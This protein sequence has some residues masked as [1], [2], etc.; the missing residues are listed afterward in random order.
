[1]WDLPYD[2]LTDVRESL[3]AVDVEYV[4]LSTEDHPAMPIRPGAN[5]QM[6][7]GGGGGTLGQ[8]QDGKYP[9]TMNWGLKTFVDAGPNRPGGTRLSLFVK[10]GDTTERLSA[11]SGTGVIIV[12]DGQ[13]IDNPSNPNWQLN[14]NTKAA[15]FLRTLEKAINAELEESMKAYD[16][17]IVRIQRMDYTGKVGDKE[18]D[19]TYPVVMEAAFAFQGAATVPAVPVTPEPAPAA[20]PLPAP[21]PPLGSPVLAPTLGVVP[22]VAAPV[23]PGLGVVPPVVA[24]VPAPL[25]PPGV[26][27]LAAV[28]PVAAPTAS[29]WS[30]QYVAWA[31][32]TI[33]SLLQGQTRVELKGLAPDAMATHLPADC[34]A[35]DDQIAVIKMLMEPLFLVTQQGWLYDREQHA[36]IVSPTDIPF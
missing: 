36:L 22:P 8:L 34:Q 13:A 1:M 24:L 14:R 35:G 27:P 21:A 12:D 25:A 3:G 33:A 2:F 15:A 17:L 9:I 20:L 10:S 30:A 26:V 18:L 23:S 32:Q 19:P 7:G 16:G 5:N 6:Q 4:G 29:P 11:G 31:T 28:P